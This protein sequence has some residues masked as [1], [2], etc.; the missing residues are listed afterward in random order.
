MD[1]TTPMPVSELVFPDSD[2]RPAAGNTAG[3][4]PDKPAAT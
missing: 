4:D 3:I 1:A 2:G